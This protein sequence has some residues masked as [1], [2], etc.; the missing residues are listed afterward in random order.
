MSKRF[1][2]VCL[3]NFLFAALLGLTLR[4]THINALP[5]NYRYLTHAHSHVAMLGWVY[6]MLYSLIVHYFIP[7][8]KPVF[9]RLFWVTEIAVVGM[10]LS[11]P[12]QGYAAVSITFSTLHILCSYYF[13][14]LVWKHHKIKNK[15]SRVL[16]KAAIIFM[17]IST[18]GVWCLGPAVTMAG[19]ASAFYQIAIQFFLHFQ[20]NGWFVFAVI[21]LFF[22]RLAICDSKEFHWFFKLFIAATI[23]TMALPVYWF[24]PHI[25]L[26]WINGIGVVLQ[27]LVIFFF[28]K[29]IRS[30]EWL[31]LI[32]R[33]K[34]N[35]ILYQFAV[36]CFTLKI[37][38]Q[39][40]SLIPAI[41]KELYSY[42]NFVIGFIHLIML[43]AVTG[44]LFSFIIE[45]GLVRFNKILQFAIY[46]FLL[47]FVLTEMTLLVQGSRFYFNQG[48][49]PGYFTLLFV[50]SIFLT[51]G[52]F[53]LLIN[54]IS[55][56]NLTTKTRFL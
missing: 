38:F 17:L 40:V 10:L 4:Y 15:P 52:I 22:N 39:S 25:L 56:K 32:N 26:L 31:D 29:I 27:F 43:G 11:F 55:T 30:Y 8:K 5:I 44:F 12:F 1:V 24:A 42:H 50:F 54:I 33:S 19:Q 28:F 7:E 23:L 45:S 13:A 41:S 35:K 20:F 2:V 48:L 53:L 16:L 3:C 14:F 46:I 49:L 6:L 36:F 34:L 21:A 37:V 9:N 18:L 47:G 51:L